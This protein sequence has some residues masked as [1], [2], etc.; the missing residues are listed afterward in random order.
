MKQIKLIIFDMDGVMTETSEQHYLAWKAMAKDIDI[1]I[2]RSF[3][4]KLKGVSRMDSLNL[5][6]E[7]G[8]KIDK[9]SEEEKAALAA[10]K[11]KFYQDLIAHLTEKNLFEGMLDLLKE[12]KKKKIKIAL[13]SASRNAP[14]LLKAMNSMSYFDYIVN[15]KEIKKGKPHPDIFLK[16]AEDLNIKPEEYIGVEDA[17][18]GIES[19][20]NAGMFAVGIGDP[21]TLK[22]ADIVYIETKEFNLTEVLK[23]AVTI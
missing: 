23:K 2:D 9:Y 1:E 12:I 22:K 11:N 3:N 17:I 14:T 4:E 19:I 15:P 5:I 20:K 18:A 16:V 7:Y 6:L 21:E 13:G 10:K 8:N